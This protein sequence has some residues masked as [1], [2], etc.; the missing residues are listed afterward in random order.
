VSL[1]YVRLTPAAGDQS[2]IAAAL[3]RF[4]C[5]RGVADDPVADEVNAFVRTDDWRRGAELAVNT[6]YLFF[7]PEV[8][9]GDAIVGYVTLAVDVVRLSTGE[10]D[11]LGRIG[12]PD[13]GALRLV[14]LGVDSELQGRGLGD[15]LLKWVVG[16]A[17]AMAEEVAFRFI[18]ADV[19]LRRKEWYDVRQFV[20][21]RAAIYKP[22]EP[23]RST[24]SMRLDLLAI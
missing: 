15:A 8:G 16:K 3:T 1:T 9:G 18:I 17:R 20:V 10:R 22:E 4:D 24:I 7:D 14:M 12:F 19:N 5:C 13:F 23:N 6:T 2:D 21:N 11:R